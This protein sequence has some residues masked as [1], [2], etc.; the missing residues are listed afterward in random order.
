MTAVHTAESPDSG[1]LH[2]LQAESIGRETREVFRDDSELA[3]NRLYKELGDMSIE[4]LIAQEQLDAARALF[5]EQTKD[6]KKRKVSLM[7]RLRKRGQLVEVECFVIPIEDSRKVRL[8][9]AQGEEVATRNMT[10]EERQL[11]LQFK[12]TN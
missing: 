5:R 9:T 4:E 1:P 6:I 3:Q 11:S 7:Q 8:V 12:A 10:A 2:T